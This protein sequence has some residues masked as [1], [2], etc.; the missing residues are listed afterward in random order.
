M[1]IVGV[2]SFLQPAVPQ[3]ENV[4][5]V[6]AWLVKYDENIKSEVKLL[7]RTIAGPALLKGVQRDAGKM[8]STYSAKALQEHMSRALKSLEVQIG[9]MQCAKGSRVEHFKEMSAYYKI[10]LRICEYF[11]SKQYGVPFQNQSDIEA[12]LI[13]TQSAL[14]MPIFGD[15]HKAREFAVAMVSN[16]RAQ[17]KAEGTLNLSPDFGEQLLKKATID[18]SV[19]AELKKKREDGVADDDIRWWWSLS[20]LERRVMLADDEFHKFRMFTSFVRIDGL[21][22]ADAGKKMLK[23]HPLYDVAAG[24]T[25]P[26]ADDRPLPIELKR[27]VNDWRMQFIRQGA[28]GEERMIQKID[29]SSSFNAL[30]RREIRDG[31]L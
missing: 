23:Y 24:E 5:E 19:A 6:I 26:T 14:Y 16:A 11:L 20:E 31:I 27:R 29:G 28:E 8:V 30:V 4:S 9:M 22:P 15:A 2:F 18:A 21:A 3:I 17:A 12:R 1:F 7:R 10:D 25:A 13:E